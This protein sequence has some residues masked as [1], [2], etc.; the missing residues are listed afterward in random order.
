MLVSLFT[1]QLREAKRLVQGYRAGICNGLGPPGVG[2][3]RLNNH[4]QECEKWVRD[5]RAW[6]SSGTGQ[7]SK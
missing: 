6:Q 7:L 1:E 3:I 5:S 2:V 4:S